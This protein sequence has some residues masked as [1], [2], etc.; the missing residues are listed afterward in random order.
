MFTLWFSFIET[1]GA[2]ILTLNIQKKRHRKKDDRYFIDIPHIHAHIKGASSEKEN[3]NLASVFANFMFDCIFGTWRAFF[4]VVGG[5][6]TQIQ[7]QKYSFKGSIN[8]CILH[9]FI[10]NNR[11]KLHMLVEC[12]K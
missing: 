7:R 12:S 6:H 4:F 8:Q 9:I 5:I 3:E 1:I 10:V 2:V 11:N